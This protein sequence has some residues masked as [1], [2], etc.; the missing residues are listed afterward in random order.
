MTIVFD[1]RLRRPGCV[2]LQAAKGGTVPA[3][4]FQKFFPTETW[5]LAPTPDMHTF[6][7]TEEQL[8]QLSAMAHAAIECVR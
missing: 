4:D 6:M 5:L 7:V 3:F 1:T 8:P 2:L